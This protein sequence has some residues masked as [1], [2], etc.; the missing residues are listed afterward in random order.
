MN[1]EDLLNKLKSQLKQFLFADEIEQINE[2]VEEQTIVEEEVKIEQSIEEN[3]EELE[4][5]E[6]SVEVEIERKDEDSMDETE[7][8]KEDLKYTELS[9]KINELELS[10]KDLISIINGV[11]EKTMNFSK[12]L[13]EIKNKPSIEP[14]KPKHIFSEEETDP[15]KNRIENL[16]NLYK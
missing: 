16:K 11:G 3:K 4:T 12:E 15:I 7:E 14:I 2:K 1:R 5:I 13:E 10:I 8:D 9:N 6:Q